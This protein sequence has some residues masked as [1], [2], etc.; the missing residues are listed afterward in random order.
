MRLLSTTALI[1]ETIANH[2][3]EG[4]LNWFLCIYLSLVHLIALAAF[5]KVPQCRPE[6]LFFA[7]VLMPLTYVFVVYYENV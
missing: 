2:Y 4:N 7:F 6:T 5:A 3:C 1:P